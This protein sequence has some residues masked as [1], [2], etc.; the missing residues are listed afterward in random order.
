M[1]AYK[2]YLTQR[3]EMWCH[4]QF[5]TTRLPKEPEGMKRFLR[6]GFG[7][8]GSFLLLLSL[9]HHQSLCTA[10]TMYRGEVYIVVWVGGSQ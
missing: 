7:V 3:H 10:P 9:P 5:I 2:G 6:Q 8:P 1:P 4:F